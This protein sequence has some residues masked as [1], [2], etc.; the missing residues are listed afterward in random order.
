MSTSTD[1]PASNH[2]RAGV[3]MG[4]N[5]VETPVMATLRATSPFAR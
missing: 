1:F 2:T 3:T 4:A 5:N